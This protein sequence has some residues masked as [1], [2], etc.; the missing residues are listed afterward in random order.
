[1]A[2]SG[3]DIA[4]FINY[5]EGRCSL[6]SKSGVDSSYIAKAMGGNGHPQA[7]GFASPSSEYTGFNEKGRAKLVKRIVEVATA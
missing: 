3:S 4:A 6:R 7:G 2:K 5:S 1:M